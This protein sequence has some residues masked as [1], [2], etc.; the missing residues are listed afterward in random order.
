MAVR[1]HRGANVWSR[2]GP[3]WRVRKALDDEAVEHEVVAGPWRPRNRAAVIAV[4]GQALYPAIEFGDGAS[5]CAESQ[6][7][8]RAIR[9][10][11]LRERSGAASSQRASG[12]C[13]AA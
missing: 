13:C 9:S 1:L 7:M 11:R 3:G 12:G 6:E 2:I 5:Y 4:T 8:A 10:G